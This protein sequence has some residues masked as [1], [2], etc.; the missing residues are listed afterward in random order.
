MQPRLTK[1]IVEPALESA[2]KSARTIM[3]HLFQ[4]YVLAPP[5]SRVF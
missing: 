3:G 1:S 4:R 2:M 5:S